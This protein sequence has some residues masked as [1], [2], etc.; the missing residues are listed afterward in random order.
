MQEK[1]EF[2]V[3]SQENGAS[4]AEKGRKRGF[5]EAARGRPLRDSRPQ[6]ADTNHAHH[7][8]NAR[9]TTTP[10]APAEIHLII[11]NIYRKKQEDAV[12]PS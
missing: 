8:I 6:N 7:N 3:Y 1:R 9:N 10:T 11:Y 5:T 4:K 12:A 2:N